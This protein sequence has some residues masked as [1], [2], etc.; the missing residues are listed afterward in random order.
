MSIKLSY[1][2]SC[3][4]CGT[5][6]QHFPIVKSLSRVII[7]DCQNCKREI[8]SEIG[9][10]KYL[11]FLIYTHAVFALL[12]IPFV[13]SIVAE[14]WIMAIISICVFLI[15]IWPVAIIL[16]ASSVRLRVKIKDQ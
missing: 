5:S 14:K 12:A 6:G 7:K 3:P 9:C 1:K 15:L 11:L 13:F 8:E 16:H 2:F 10:G 4:L